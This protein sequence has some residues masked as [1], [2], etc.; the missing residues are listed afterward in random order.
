M[1][2]MP[3]KIDVELKAR[4]VRLVSEHVGEHSSLTVASAARATPPL[5]LD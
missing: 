5:R 2:T 1:P 3:K 4:P